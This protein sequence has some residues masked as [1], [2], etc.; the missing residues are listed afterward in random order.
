MTKKHTSDLHCHLN[1]SFSLEFLKIAA[2][3]NKCMDVFDQLVIVK[4]DY[5][6]RTS[7]QPT[8]GFPVELLGLVW[9]Q[10]G[11]IHKIIQDL[12]DISEGVVDVVQNATAKYLEVRTTPKPM[13]SK[14]RDDYIDA[15]ESGLVRANQ[16]FTNKK[17]IGLLSLDRATHTRE[18]AQHF[19]SRIVTSPNK[20]LAGLDISG[21]PLANRTLTAGQLS[22]VIQLVL[23]SGLAIA[24]HMGESDSDIE[25]QDTD[26][27][28]SALEHWKSLQHAQD[29][30]PLHSRV[31]LGHCIFLTELQKDKIAKLG[32]PIEVCPT[33]HSKMNWHLEKDPHP[34]TAI[35][36]DLSDPIAVGTDDEVVFGGSAKSEF[37]KCVRFFSNNQQLNRKELKTHQSSF[38]FSS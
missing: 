11:L 3:K 35:Y 19:I 32:I 18:D 12:T 23:N 25:R 28:L 10:F 14:S 22:E 21:N 4:Q 5:L 29:K 37:N 8:D 30:N 6:Q 16:K 33:C 26:A 24:I 31:R 7:Q 2:A 13:A 34:V 20:V 9:K 17:A 1:G 38:R 36:K 15:F 27:V